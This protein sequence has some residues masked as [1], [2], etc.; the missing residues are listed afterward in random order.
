LPGHWKLVVDGKREIGYWIDR[1]LSGRGIATEA[2]S[3]FLRL[4][5]ARALHD[6]VATHNAVSI[7][8]LQNCGFTLRG[9]EETASDAAE[10][11]HVFLRLDAWHRAAE[12]TKPECVQCVVR[13]STA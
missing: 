11:S 1:A 9:P 3:A 6:A 4:E 13:N 12:T 5:Q 10:P 2:L 7:R 8:V